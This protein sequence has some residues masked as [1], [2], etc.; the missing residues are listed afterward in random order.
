MAAIRR[1]P[2]GKWQASVR[3]PNGKRATKTDTS[4]QWIR[5]WAENLESDIRRGLWVDPTTQAPDHQNLTVG[6]WREQWL[7]TRVRGYNTA[8]REDND[9]N[10]RVSYWADHRMVEITRL[11][12]QTWLAAMERAAET[13]HSRAQALGHL[14]Q[15]LSAAVD[16][17]RL[18]TDPTKGIKKPIIPK[19]VDRILTREEWARLDSA[20]GND[21]MVRLM[22]WCGLRWGEAA[23]LHGE[24][25]DLD[26]RRIYIV[27]VRLQTGDIK[28]VPKSPAGFRCVP[29][30]VD[31]GRTLAPIVRPGPIFTSPKGGV[32]R[33]D[34]WRRRFARWVAAA[35]L[36]DPQ[37]TGHDLRHS[38]ATWLADAG[39]RIHDI[40]SL[41][42]HADTRST[43][44]YVHSSRARDARALDALEGRP[45]PD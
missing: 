5:G 18:T 13:P 16:H 25:I 40:A 9:W 2:S 17:D 24:S 23:G 37:L 44:R 41:I 4:K 7:A 38:Y 15:I 1:L 26:H 11:D 30:P 8:K 42:G 20:T 43:N 22:L 19:H 32:L 29:V 6:Q 33:Y 31:A 35:K 21:P 34:N 39:V 27:R 12:V 10:I 45:V 3:L 36:P 14:R 28:N